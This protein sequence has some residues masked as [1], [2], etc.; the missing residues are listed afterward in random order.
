MNFPHCLATVDSSG[1]TLNGANSI[2]RRHERYYHKS[3]TTEPARSVVARRTS[4]DATQLKFRPIPLDVTLG[5]QAKSAPRIEQPKFKV[6]L[7]KR[8][9]GAEMKSTSHTT[10][11]PGCK[12]FFTP[13]K[14]KRH[15]KN[16]ADLNRLRGRYLE[17]AQAKSDALAK[18]VAKAKAKATAEL[19]AAARLE[20]AELR[21]TPALRKTL[22]PPSPAS[23]SKPVQNGAFTHLPFELI[24]P[25]TSSIE[26]VGRSFGVAADDEAGWYRN[27]IDPERLQL[28]ETLG[29]ANRYGGVSGWSGYVVFEFDNYPSWVVVECAKVGNAAFVLGANWRELIRHTK[30]YLSD[31][32]GHGSFRVTHRGGWLD[33]IKQY[34]RSTPRRIDN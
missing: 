32:E 26:H 10:M 20:R 17:D 14:I 6:K 5:G 28:L 23:A 12:W 31:L 24:P 33:K 2:L 16:C 1:M 15:A 21:Q 22:E 19:E 34:L 18:A 4:A 3:T 30:S 11:C 9:N 8:P 7:A 13:K 27:R 29:K 25:G